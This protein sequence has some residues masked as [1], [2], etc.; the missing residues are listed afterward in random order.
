MSTSFSPSRN[1]GSTKLQLGVVSRLRSSSLKKPPEPLRRAVADWLSSSSSSHHGSPSTVVSEASR[2]LRVRNS[3]TLILWFCCS[4]FEI[5]Y[6]LFG[7]LL[8]L[9]IKFNVILFNLPLWSHFCTYS[10]V[11]GILFQHEMFLYKSF[12]AFSWS[13]MQVGCRIN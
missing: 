5:L 6:F 10:H 12:C 11:L 4:S 3:V 1:P 2:I 8:G 9:Q 13:C 7:T